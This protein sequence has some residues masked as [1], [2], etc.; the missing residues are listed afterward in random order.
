MADNSML[1]AYL[2]QQRQQ[3]SP[4]GAL[5]AGINAGMGPADPYGMAQN[6]GSPAGALWGQ[7]SDFLTGNRRKKPYDKMDPGMLK[8]PAAED[9]GNLASSLGVYSP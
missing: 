7:I 5:S 2:M 3:Q 6:T 1:A 4:L 9:G 8:D